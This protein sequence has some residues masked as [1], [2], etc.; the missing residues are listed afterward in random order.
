MA[1]SASNANTTVSRINKI[2]TTIQVANDSLGFF[3]GHVVHQRLDGGFRSFY[4]T[5]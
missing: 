1:H 4:H 2:A 3:R 5:L